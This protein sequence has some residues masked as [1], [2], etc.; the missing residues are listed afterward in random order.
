[1]VVIGGVGS[2]AQVLAALARHGAHISGVL[3]LDEA[4]AHTT[5]GFIALD[6][7]AQAAGAPLVRFARVN[8]PGIIAQGR[9]WAPDILWVVGLSQLV[10]EEWIRMP[11]RGAIGFHPTQLPQGRGR[12]PIA[13]LALGACPGAATFFELMNEADAGGILEQEPFDVA[14]DAA[15]A[16]IVAEAEA[17]MD[18]AL[19]RLVPRLLQGRWDARPQNDACASY[20]GRRAPEDGRLDWQL[21]ATTLQ[22]LVRASST[23]HPGAYTWVGD[24]R[25]VVQAAVAEPDAP[26]HGVPGRVLSVAPGSVRVM[27]GAGA[28][29]LTDVRDDRDRPVADLKVGQRLGV[30]ADDEIIALRLRVADLEARLA[31]LTATVAALPHRA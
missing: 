8:D 25:L 9:A 6:A 12:A 14:E 19:D 27:T 2:T 13:W 5:T 1:M 26:W 24:R 17:A 16:A 18:R 31:D 7:A 30:A 4:R 20:L 28:L 3:A 15:A 21:P 22:R 29:V 11:T 10:A 23:P